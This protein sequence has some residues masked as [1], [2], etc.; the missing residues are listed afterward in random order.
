MHPFRNALATLAVAV[1]LVAAWP[2]NWSGTA[3]AQDST[4]MPVAPEFTGIDHWY[5]TPPLTMAGLRGK[6]VLVEFWTHECI[7]CLH[8]LPHTKAL[9]EKYAGQGLVVVGVHTPEYDSERVPANVQAAI[10]RYGITWPVA[11]DNGY[12]TWNAYGNQ[13]WPALYL[14]DRDGRVV[15]RHFGEGNYEQTEE[16]VRQLLEKA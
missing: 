12:E 4:A 1:A 10:K 15:Y 2:G 3:R 5:N 7:N 13:Y 14:I 6:V 9:Y 11:T 16:R 8:V